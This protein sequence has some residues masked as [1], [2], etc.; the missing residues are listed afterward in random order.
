MQGPALGLALALVAGVLS[1]AATFLP[2][3]IGVRWGAGVIF[4]ALVLAP[5]H[6]DPTRRVALIALS[7]GAY[8]SA[9]WL[10]QTLYS[11]SFASAL[12]SCAAAGVFGVLVVAIGTSLLAKSAVDR[13]AL[14]KASVSGA[15]AGVLIGL[16]V[17]ADD[18]SVGQQAFLLAGYVVWQVGYAAAHRLAPA[19]RAA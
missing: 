18:E 16:C 7:A 12:A 15:I 9:V 17:R 13:R 2:D 1:Y 10:A 6:P 3:S 11:G 8:R 5:S 19:E 4:G 14:A